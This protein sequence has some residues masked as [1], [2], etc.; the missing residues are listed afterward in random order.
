MVDSLCQLLQIPLAQ[1]P[2]S[3]IVKPIVIVLTVNR[4]AKKDNR[5]SPTS[6]HGVVLKRI[7]KERSALGDYA[8][9]NEF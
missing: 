8:T 4:S 6:D 5:F 3:I 7:L 2:Y 9:Q 1:C